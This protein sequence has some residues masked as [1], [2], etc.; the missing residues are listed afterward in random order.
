[1]GVDMIK[2]KPLLCAV[3][4]PRRLPW[5]AWVC[6]LGVSYHRTQD[7][8]W[9]R[10]KRDASRLARQHGGHFPHVQVWKVDF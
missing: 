7:A 1:M 10:A 2:K 3:F 8:A 5:A 4:N 6:G 9:R